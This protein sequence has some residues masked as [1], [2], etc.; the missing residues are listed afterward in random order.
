MEIQRRAGGL[1]HTK[2]NLVEEVQFGKHL[3][4]CL[5]MLRKGRKDAPEREKGCVRA[6]EGLR[7][8]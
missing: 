2:D 1:D 3:A 4:G 5:G 7:Q 8:K 6:T